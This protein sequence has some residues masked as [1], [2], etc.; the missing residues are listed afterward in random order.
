MSVEENAAPGF[1][2][3]ALA[4]PVLSALDEVG[5]ETPSPIQAKTIPLIL[6]G[7]DLVGQAQTGTGKTAAFALPLLSRLDLSRSE[8]QVLVLA[9][10]RELAIQVA[11][12]F[13]RYA[14]HMRGFHVLPIYGGQDYGTQLRGLRR[15]AQ[16]VVGTPGRVMDHMRKGSLRLEGLSALV[17]DEADEMLRMGFID[18]VEWILEQTPEGRQIALFS[19]TMPSAIRRIAQAHLKAPREVT[20]QLTSAAA[21]TIR[22]RYW[23][24][25]GV[26]KLDALTRILEVEPFDGIIVFVRTKIATSELAEKLRARGYAAAPLNGDIA[27]KERERTVERLKRGD[28]D[29]LVATDV[30]ARGLDVERVS[31]VINY[32]IPYDTESYIHRIG[33][34]GRAGRSGDA[35]LFVAPRERRLLRAIEKATRRPIEAMELP[36]TE[37][38]NDKRIALFKERI[39]DTLATEELGFFYQLLEQYQQEHNIP[40]LEIAAALARLVQ[41]DQPLLLTRPKAAEKRHPKTAQ[42]QGESRGKGKKEKRGESRVEGSVEK[43]GEPRHKSS[44]PSR[45]NDR[46]R[47][48]VGRRDGVQPGNIVG[49]IANE[50]GLESRF[51]QEITIHDDHSLVDLPKGMPKEVFHDL[52]KTWVCGRR[53]NI[54]RIGADDAPGKHRKG[55]KKGKSKKIGKTSGPATHER[56]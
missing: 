55:K 43:R 44:G 30:A 46:Y 17:L 8:T 1:R 18:D 51:I 39:T 2:D 25:S 47:L 12:A 41:G 26:H 20:I 11:E 48:E 56:D 3:L 37:I 35:V 9:P 34:T 29:I 32:D 40:A 24:V 6:D 49:A 50:A 53:L 45:D 52:R 4:A 42:G 13:Q 5:Y 23:L 27:Q 33:R 7:H 16:V 15:G 21:E 19:A 28:L 10:T 36:S 31:H 38:I 14:A 54:S 22:Q